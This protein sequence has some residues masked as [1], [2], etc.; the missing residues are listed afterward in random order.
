MARAG[1]IAGAMTLALCTTAANAA[2]SD[3][4]PPLETQARQESPAFGGF[5]AQR[6]RAFFDGTHGQDWSC[7]SCHT[8]NPLEAGRHAATGRSIAALA[9][10]ANPKRLSDPA[11]VEKWFRRN[12]KDVLRRECTAT[13]KGDVI[14]YLL[15][16]K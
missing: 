14:S 5:S 6:G 7:S 11:K 10:A 16:L 15:S 1:M 12:C 9:P 2:G 13:E 3:L 8:R 4:L